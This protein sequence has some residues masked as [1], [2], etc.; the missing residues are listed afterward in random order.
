M[1]KSYEHWPFVDFQ[2]CFKSCSLTRLK[3]TLQTLYFS[4]NSCGCSQFMLLVFIS[5]YA[6]FSSLFSSWTPTHWLDRSSSFK[7]VLQISVLSL[8]WQMAELNT[9]W[10]KHVFI[11]KPSHFLTQMRIIIIT[12]SSAP[13]IRYSSHYHFHFQIAV[14]ARQHFCL[15]FSNRSIFSPEVGF[16]YSSSY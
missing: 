8:F 12:L 14:T 1:S 2:D 16:G 9:F 4:I 5:I 13:A 3:L 11:V 6:Y 7:R 10:L 15:L